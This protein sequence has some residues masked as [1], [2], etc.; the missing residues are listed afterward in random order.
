[1]LNLIFYGK[2]KLPADSLMVWSNLM[3]FHFCVKNWN[4]T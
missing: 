1:M 2:T 4:W 3:K